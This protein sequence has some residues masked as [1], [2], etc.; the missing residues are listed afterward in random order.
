MPR[1]KEM[2]TY[3]LTFAVKSDE[4]LEETALGI[5]GVVHDAI[6]DCALQYEANLIRS[7]KCKEEN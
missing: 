2:K 7:T 1:G 4:S 5:E 6:K 3:L